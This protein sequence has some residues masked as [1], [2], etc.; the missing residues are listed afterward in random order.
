MINALSTRLS[1]DPALFLPAWHSVPEQ[2][3]HK[4]ASIPYCLRN[5]L[6]T[7]HGRSARILRKGVRGI[8]GN[9][10]FCRIMLVRAHLIKEDAHECMQRSR[11]VTFKNC[12]PRTPLI[13]LPPTVFGKDTILFFRHKNWK[14][15]DQG[16]CSEGPRYLDFQV[17]MLSFQEIIGSIPNLGLKSRN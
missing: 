12:N 4:L 7:Y 2:T 16:A 9:T 1:Y 10:F 3:W 6:A 5:L 11:K 14:E 15:A 8:F 17:D 13:I